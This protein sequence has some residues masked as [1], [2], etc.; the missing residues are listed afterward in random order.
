MKMQLKDCIILRYIGFRRVGII[1]RLDNVINR[2]NGHNVLVIIELGMTCE[3]E[4]DWP[5]EAYTGGCLRCVR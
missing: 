4:H 2:S 5:L 3:S 1:G